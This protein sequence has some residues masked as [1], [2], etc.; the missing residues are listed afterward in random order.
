MTSWPVLSRVFGSCYSPSP[1]S[2][3]LAMRRNMR[4]CL[5]S[6]GSTHSSLNIRIVSPWSICHQ[7][8]TESLKIYSFYRD[9]ELLVQTCFCSSYCVFHFN[10]LYCAVL[11]ILAAMPVFLLPNYPSDQLE[12]L[13]ATPNCFPLYCR[14]FI[15]LEWPP[16]SHIVCLGWLDITI[17]AWK[18]RGRIPV[19][20]RL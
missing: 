11:H 18:K 4:I 9:L 1:L 15:A 6:L 17:A 7:P 5:C 16:K 8:D 3:S 20:E 2:F 12:L 19:R 13:Q 14:L 10:L